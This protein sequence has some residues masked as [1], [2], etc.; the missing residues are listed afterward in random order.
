MFIQSLFSTSKRCRRNS[1]SSFSVL[2]YEAVEP[3]RVLAAS[4]FPGN[5]CPPDLVLTSVEPQTATVD[6]TLAFNFFSVGATV[7]DSDSNGDPTNDII[8]IQLDPDIGTDTPAGATVDSEGN[9]SWTPTASQIGTHEIVVIAVDGGAT[10]LADAEVFT[11]NVIES[12][13]T[14]PF[15]DLNGALAGADFSAT[16]T[17]DGPAI[18]IVADTMSLVDSDSMTIVGASIQLANVMDA[19]AESL[20]VVTSGTAVSA[21]Y[22]SATGIL[23][24]SGSDSVENYQQ[25]LR[26]LRYQNASQA[27]VEANR[28]IEI[29]VNDGNS[30]S[31]TRTSTVTVVAVNDAP[32]LAEIANQDVPLGQLFE[33]T[34]TAVDVDSAVLTFQLDR[35]NPNSTMPA[36]A[37]LAQNGNTAILTFTPN[38][39]D[40]SGPFNFFVLVTDSDSDNPLAD[41]E[42]FSISVI[43]GAPLIDANGSEQGTDFSTGF[44]ENTESILAVATGLTVTDAN[45]TTLVSAEVAISNLLDGTAESLSVETG[46]T[47]I[48]AGYVES[49][50]VLTLTGTA[51]LA[52]YQDVLRSLRYNNSSL[53]PTAANRKI[54][55]TVNDGRNDSPVATT[56]VVIQRVSGLALRWNQA[57]RDAI[58]NTATT[59]PEATRSLAM[60]HLAMVDVINA[61][62]D[63]AAVYVNQQRPADASLEAAVS[64]AANEVLRHLFPNQEAALSAVLAEAL[65]DI[66]DGT[67]KDNGLAFGQQIGQAIVAI[68]STD[69]H[70]SFVEHNPTSGVGRWQP[71][72]PAFDA[73]LLPQWPSLTPFLITPSSFSA[74]GPPA[75]D[76]V[77]YAAALNEVQE[78]GLADSTVRTAE[79]TEIARF[80]TDGAGTETPPG[81][82]NQIA[83]QVAEEQQNSLSANIRLFAKLNTALA[84]AAIVAFDSK[85][86]S[87]FWRPVTAI[88]DAAFDSNDETIA[89]ESWS[90]LLINPNFPEYVSGHSTFS[91]AAATVLTAL[92]GDDVSFTSES[93]GLP[94]VQR[95]FTSFNQAADEAGRSRVYGGIHFEFSNQDGLAIGRQIGESVLSAFDSATDLTSPVIQVDALP[96]AIGANITIEGQILDGISG[97]D[98]STIQVDDGEVVSLSVDSIG[99]FTFTTTLTEDGTYSFQIRARDVVGNVG[100]RDFPLTLDSQDPVF[101]ISTPV[102]DSDLSG[103]STLAGTIDGTGSAIIQST[104][105]IDNGPVMP[106]SIVNGEFSVPMDVARLNPGSHSINVSVQDAAGNAATSTTQV[107]LSDRI[108]FGISSIAPS[109]G[110][111]EVGSKFRP[112]VFFTRPVK[113]S[114]LTG[115]NFF[116]TDTTGTKIPANIVPASDGSFAWLFFESAL[117]SASTITLHLDG[118]SILAEANDSPLDAN[119]DGTQGEVFQSQFTT[120]SLAALAG[121]S[122]LGRVFDPGPDLK[123]MTNDDFRAGADGILHTEDDEFLRPIANAKV[124]ILGLENEFVFT[125]ADGYFEIPATPSGNVKL[126]IDGRTATNGPEG[127]FFPE[128]V[129][130]LRLE[131]GRV[132][133][134]MGTMGT[135]AEREANLSRDEVYLPRVQIS[136]LQ[137]ISNTAITT[138][139]VAPESASNLTPE[140]RS[141][142]SLQV[143]PNSVIGENGQ[144]LANAQIGISTVPPELVRD[145]LPAGLIQHTFDITIQAP[146]AAAFATP[147]TMTFPNVFDAAP[148]TKLNF[149]SFDHTTGLLVIEGTATVSADGLSATTDPGMGITKPGWHGLTPPGSPSEEP[150]DPT[151]THDRDVPPELGVKGLQNYLFVGDAGEINLEFSNNARQLNPRTSPCSLENHRASPVLVDITFSESDTSAFLFGLS[152]S[153]ISANQSTTVRL[154]IQ[155]GQTES[156]NAKIKPLLNQIKSFKENQ[157]FGSRFHIDAYWIDRNGTR[158]DLGP[159]AGLPTDDLYVYRFLDISD[160]RHSDARI[161]FPRTV[162]TLD[163]SVKQSIPVAFN[164]DASAKPT[165]SIPGD[166][167]SVSANHGGV[168][169]HPKSTTVN[170]EILTVVAPDSSTVG[171]LTIAGQGVAPQKVM[172]STVE[173]S[174]KIKEIFSSRASLPEAASLLSLFRD[175]INDPV[176][177]ELDVSNVAQEIR[178]RFSQIFAALDQNASK[179][180]VIT[181]S[182]SGQGNKVN[183]LNYHVGS[184]PAN[185]TP[186][187]DRAAAAWADFGSNYFNS[188]LVPNESKY[189]VPQVKYLFTGLI[190][191]SIDDMNNS[192]ILPSRGGI[193][194]NIDYLAIK[195]LNSTPQ[196][197]RSAFINQFA[198]VMAHEI[199]HNLGAIHQRTPSKLYVGEDEL[200]GKGPNLIADIPKI[201]P[202]FKAIFKAALGLPVEDKEVFDKQDGALPYYKKYVNLEEYDPIKKTGYGFNSIGSPTPGPG[203]SGGESGFPEG[204]IIVLDGPGDDFI[205]PNV[206]DNLDFGNVIVDGTAGVDATRT[207]YLFNYGDKPL[208]VSEISTVDIDEGLHVVGFSGPVTLAPF[209]QASSDQSASRLRL[210]VTFDPTIIG[211]L[212]GELLISSDSAFDNQY[213]VNLTGVAQSQSGSIAVSSAT[214]NLGGVQLG[215]SALLENFATVVNDG[216]QSMEVSGVSGSGSGE[217]A[218]RNLPNFPLTLESG[219]SFQL[220]VLFAPADLGLRRGS[221][222]VFSNDLNSPSVVL[223]VVATG[224]TETSSSF[225]DYGND[226]V[227]LENLGNPNVSDVRLKS[228]SSGEWRSFLAA[229]TPYH[230]VIFDPVSDLVAHGFFTSAQDGVRTSIPTPYF[231]ASLALDSDNDGLPDDVEFAIGTSALAVDSN[232]DG[233]SDFAAIRQ[234][235]DPLAGRPVTT[236]I[237][238]SLPL[239]GEANQIVVVENLD[240][241]RKRTAY[242]ATGSY[243]LAIVDVSNFQNPIVIGQID[244]PGNAIDVAVDTNSSLAV[245]ATGSGGLSIVDILQPTS[246]Q[247]IRTVAAPATQVEVKDGVAFVVVSGELQAFDVLTGTR[248]QR[249]SLGASTITGLAREG[250][251]LFAMDSANNLRAVDI[252]GPEMFARGSLTMPQ[253]G[254]SLFVGNGIAYVSATSQFTGGFATANVSDPENLVLIAGAST[255]SNSASPNPSIVANGSGLGIMTVGGGQG[256]GPSLNV[257]DSRDPSQTNQFVTSYALPQS[258]RSVTVA[259]GVAYVADGSGG[260]LIVN[261]QSFDSQGTVPTANLDSNGV[262][263]DPDTDGVQVLEGSSVTVKAIVDDDV[264]VRSVELLVNGI[265]VQS[266]L[267]FPFN[268]SATMP[269]ISPDQMTATL[270]IRAV[271]TGGNSTTSAIVEVQLTPDTTPPTLASINPEDG[272]QKG[273]SFRTIQLVFSESM[274]P[275]TIVPANF[276]LIDSSNVA[277][278]PISIQL[279]ANDSIVQLTYELLPLGNYTFNGDSSN[280]TDRAGNV[281][282][283]SAIVSHFE[284]VPIS[285][286]FINTAGGFWDD[287]DNWDTGEAPGPDDDVAISIAPNA[288]VTF[289]SDSET[290]NSILVD[291]ELAITGGVLT[292]TENLTVNGAIAMSG[293]TLRGAN[294][295]ESNDASVMLSGGTLDGVTVNGSFTIGEN[296]AVFVRNGLTLNGTVTLGDTNGYGYLQFV[297]TQTLGGNGA[298]VFG[299]NNGN[300][301]LGVGDSG[302]TLTI[303]ADIIVQGQTGYVGYN[304]NRG[305]NSDVGLINNGTI[306]ADVAGFTIT[307]DA[308]NGV[309]N[310]GIL[311]AVDGAT[312][313]LRGNGWTSSGLIQADTGSR[314]TSNASFNNAANI[315]S[316]GGLGAVRSN[317]SI[318]GGVLTI[319]SETSVMLSGGTLDG[320]T[321]NGSFTIGEND[322]VFVRNGLTLNGTATLGDT[323]GY[324]YLQFVETQTLGGNGAVV[325]G[326]NNGNNTLGVGDSGATLTVDENII[327]QGQTGYIGYNPNRGGNS[328]VGLINNGT[329]QADVAGFTVTVDAGNGVGNAGI[330]KAV[331]GATLSLRG[332]GWT[333]SG[334]IQ[335]DTGSRIT[336]NAS[337]NN[338]ANIMSFGGLG[339]VRSNGS[340]LGGMLTIASETSVMLSGGT[341]D[342]VTVNGSFTIGE[343]DTVFVRNGLTLNGTATLGDTNGYGY[344]QFVETQ[345]LGGN[346][347]VVFGSN[348]GNN[349][350]GVGDSGATLTIDDNITVQ[351]QTGYV[352]YNPNRGGNSDVNVVNN[353][354]I[355]FTSGTDI[356]FSRIINDNGVVTADAAS[357]VSMGGTVRGGV[358]TVQAGARFANG[359]FDGLRLNGSFTI[360]SNDIVL[361]RNGLTLNGTAILGDT[362]GYG[363]LR[364]EETQTLNGDGVVVFGSGSG[365]NTLGV[366]DSGATLT[367]GANIVVRGQ[368]GYIGYNPNRGGNSDV[369]VVNNGTIEFTSGTD[370][371]FSRIINDNGV[372]TADA[373]SV[374]STGGAVRGGVIT[375]QA[376]ARFANGT[377]DGLTLNGSFTI[378]SNDIVLVR[379]GLTLNGTAT[380][381]DTNGYGF[382]RF[383]ETQALNGNGVVVFGS[384]SGN[385]TL[386]V[387]DSGATL[388]IGANIVV[389]GQAGY[390]GYNPNRGGNSDVSVI[391]N[392][393]I[394]ADVA[395][396]TLVVQAANEVENFGTLRAS[397]GA[398]LALR[399]N[400]WVSSGAIDAD[401]GSMVEIDAS[402]VNVDNTMSFEGLGTVESNST[403]VGGTLEIASETSVLFAGGTLDG[404]TLNGSFTIGSNDIVLV[405]NGLTL[406][407]TATLGDTNGYGFLRFEETQAL[408]GNGVVV[409]GSGSGNNTL[410]VGDSGATLTIGA[411]IVVRGQAGYVGY[412]PNRGGNSDV[413]VINNGT[414]QADVAGATLVVQAANEVEN[415][416]TLRASNGAILALRGNGWVSSGAIDADAGSMVEIDASFVNVDN[417]MSFEG[418]GTVES[419]STVVGGTLEIASETSVLFA[420]GTLDGLTLNGSFTIG[421]NDIVLVRN[422]LTLNGTATLGDTNGYGFL[423]FEETQAL[424][425]NGVVVFGSGSGNNTLGVGD[426]GATL[427]IG[428][429]IVVRGQAGYVGYNP[430][431][432]G[433]SDVSVINN[434][435][436]EFTSGTDIRFSSIINDN[437]VVTADASSVVSTG[438]AVRGGVITAQAGA[439]FAN[440]TFDGLTLNGSFTIGSNDIVLVRNGLTLNGTATLGDTNG[441]GFLRFEETQTLNGDGV[442][443]FGSGS[444]NN[445]LGVG[446]SGATLT[447]GANIV[448]RGQ[449]GYIGYNPN[450]GGNS[451]V[452][453]VNNGTIEF[454]E[455]AI[456]ATF[457][458]AGVLRPGGNQSRSLTIGGDFTQTNGA[459]L[460]IDLASM[461]SFDEFVVSG[462]ATIDG[463]L[464]IVLL[465]GF[466][467]NPGEAFRL[468]TF[469]SLIGQFSELDGSGFTI[470]Y[471]DTEVR[472]IAD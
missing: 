117:P 122:L 241:V 180:I 333:S 414:I 322:T 137:D 257:Y 400:G 113:T 155:P 445:T 343:N 388:T 398:I 26:T 7:T 255:D 289:R 274:D 81:H 341:L 354:T 370:I 152:T 53:N 205:A 2:A 39:E 367:I 397:N 301:T 383:E 248:I 169:F 60:V 332:N 102:T 66:P 8:R 263:I 330:L 28:L 51:S 347:A 96:A 44:G 465:A 185:T 345:T 406:N 120:V 30:S 314:I 229:S 435:T 399:G 352:G 216:A 286:N 37:T 401:A 223:D 206:I 191:R 187:K 375:A 91:G 373:S 389:R 235:L 417:T 411:N 446:D 98:S 70:D 467:P 127:I 353:G 34:L 42:Q 128:M 40:G 281:L 47:S 342:G 453:V 64:G 346:G 178:Q 461:T 469:S 379:N 192:P 323:N 118:S 440:G 324:G 151:A 108:P 376:G 215:E 275:S 92:L 153:S 59:P 237:L 310:A 260:L 442:V 267:S 171:D 251:L 429:N 413:S 4:G 217:F 455:G 150:C 219:E 14:P 43:N 390:V 36:S 320:V 463:T 41:S 405:R 167:F 204:Q 434:G 101:A 391:N 234:G 83:L 131:V 158:H 245:V 466:E 90:S 129:M 447:I 61:W 402:F 38:A 266:A 421:S 100:V 95:S 430:N 138:I 448:V 146:D 420:G 199:G 259:A 84:D 144:V 410:G 145:M 162:V 183:L 105:Q 279:R 56:T 403:V 407:G 140:Q 85:Y 175:P 220:D 80:W 262:D 1:K 168:Q 470:E 119:S 280:L 462:I 50:G 156:I 318:L 283:G 149:L 172:F 166:N 164:G 309:G 24:L 265:I 110:S 89:D 423:R 133:T 362:N 349:T 272:T 306:Q 18:A 203:F 443:V 288:T 107:T 67:K 211:L 458:N 165:F 426:S 380:L 360:G 163:S 385:N 23:T 159:T 285:A 269:R 358:I 21:E 33:L 6:E 160:N 177:F 197:Y 94:G 300:N 9:F 230:Y 381:G 450:R 444:G 304:P 315:M 338:A 425:G 363:F 86:T 196:N 472:V 207:I 337:F 437:G 240:V 238:A 182:V 312:L 103:E 112:Q 271:D 464:K 132:N 359:T 54:E 350:L 212:S 246:P 278:N 382:L 334:L 282:G 427:T 154:T 287:P 273:K 327:V 296:D 276:S 244:L 123:P 252:S 78:L 307:V 126:A 222:A 68:R 15:L 111:V 79:Q 247:L 454:S 209:D 236:G 419:N 449:T 335:A 293:G 439:R 35:D 377:F 416:G 195:T 227:V 308:G 256:V 48:T 142:L 433:N 468:M 208:T 339:A 188:T 340:I 170:P 176:G 270:Q 22:V 321:V 148:G 193:L 198:G 326:S 88:Q 32:N 456:N 72:A 369:S 249:L 16:F 49:T 104:Y 368:T 12:Q 186:H 189:F 20:N 5:D 438:G 130:D 226:Y 17:E 393:T 460:E 277:F 125:D 63:T 218:F 139:S 157:L 19:A 452:S 194:I 412:N 356:R 225:L 366:G 294:L 319:A 378:G 361:V 253:G 141:N 436:I 344:L 174:A 106:F 336:S 210:Q 179:A 57:A 58:S 82:W 313:S 364:F 25:V 305:G 302:A 46:G 55:F 317:G 136:S 135:R 13:R 374:V 228:S 441:Y 190:N 121:T 457:L 258:P 243:G 214:S 357:V 371:R 93:A 52:D 459:I 351:G 331:D 254:G 250:S 232:G 221:I 161:D 202:S 395:G 365:N 471:L 3:R 77:E 184:L 311:K 239:Q 451:D 143:Q 328:D 408:N 65:D 303:G 292:V 201:G 75:L 325:F 115:N 10:R 404:L 291:S 76:S 415:F 268:L 134:V 386:G 62:E 213:K 173:F 384:G 396:A 97:L 284:L 231:Q 31:I 114:S 11:V 224:T 372:V 116:A 329:I 432:G 392:G 99:R 424:N 45:S 147:L 200:M 348:N 299:S 71:T 297:E 242:V 69:G 124:F 29:S 87:D 74:Q 387:G 27:P 264:Q 261:Y 394:Q 316:F 409:F 233:I 181:D 290:V 109:N 422:G 431:R 295:I 428:A 355:E 298:V 73:A 418:L